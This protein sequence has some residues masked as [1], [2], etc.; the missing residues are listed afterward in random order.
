LSAQ[1]KMACAGSGPADPDIIV[2][3]GLARNEQKIENGRS[4]REKAGK[5]D[6]Q[7]GERLRRKKKIHGS[8]RWKKKWG[9]GRKKSPPAGGSTGRGETGD[10]RSVD[11]QTEI[12]GKNNHHST[13]Y[14]K[15]HRRGS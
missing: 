6:R 7:S 14:P 1:K 5:G 4:M 3:Y 2:K 9:K 11:V 12:V 10:E 8:D 13:L 15:E